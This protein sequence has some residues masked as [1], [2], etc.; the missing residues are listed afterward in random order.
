[1]ASVIVLDASVL[2][3][4]FRSGDAH[5][6]RAFDIL[7]C[8]D[9]LV[10]HPLTLAEVLVGAVAQGVEE[11]LLE[12]LDR[13]GVE[14]APADAPSPRDLARL[15]HRQRL[16]MPDCCVLGL[17]LAHGATLATFDAKLA[18]VATTL[19]LETL[20]VTPPRAKTY[21]H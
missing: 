5:A 14:T 21:S 17:A 1:M 19:G 4:H 15:R 8:E 3:A 6:E 13:I 11:R 16:K 9:D 10:V 20:G 2:I 12:S 7:D 18:A